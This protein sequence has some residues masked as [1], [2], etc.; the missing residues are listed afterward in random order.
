MRHGN[1]SPNL[2][3]CSGALPGAESYRYYLLEFHHAN[4][5]SFGFV[6]RIMNLVLHFRKADEGQPVGRINM[7][8]NRNAFFL[9]LSDIVLLYLS[10]F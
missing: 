6:E 4:I 5:P 3:E 8:M 9:T 10:L 1:V 7:K 2:A